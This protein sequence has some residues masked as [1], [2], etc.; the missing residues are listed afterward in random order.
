MSVFYRSLVLTSLLSI[1]C[2]VSALADH[3]GI[4]T[5]PNAAGPIVTIP[6]ATLPEGKFT[7]GLS[8]EYIKSD[9]FSDA[10]L[11][12][13]ASH[14]VHAHSTDYV[15]TT[16]INASYGIT[17]ELMVSLR[18]PH[19]YRNSLRAGRHTHGGGGVVNDVEDSGNA[20]GIG[21][22]LLLGKYRLPETFIQSAVLFGMELPTGR[23]DNKKGGEKLE[24][25]HQAGSGS[26]DPVLGFAVSKPWNNWSFDASALYAW[27]TEGAQHTD[28]GDRASYGVAVS[29]RL[30]GENH[31][32]KDGHDHRHQALDL[33]LELNGEWFAKQ[34]EDNEADEDSGG[35]QMFVSPGLRYTGDS[36]WSAHA[37]VGIPV[38]NDFRQGHADTDYK[39]LLGVS[40][41]F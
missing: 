7:A 8:S 3:A 9:A 37:S 31:R 19:I 16:S 23:T 20:R 13:A 35:S 15:L 21:D 17:D 30:G 41:G 33:V 10:E 22:V 4:G 12:A 32:H 11:I 2:P 36:G 38:R 14:H 26:W 39:L 24:A 18:I 40:R 29:R 1:A 6:A 27:G 25:E 28:L 34:Q 5:G